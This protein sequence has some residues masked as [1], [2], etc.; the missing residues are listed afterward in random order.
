MNNIFNRIVKSIKEKINFFFYIICISLW[1]ESKV[2]YSIC[3][4]E[5]VMV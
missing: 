4:L 3:L 1:L 5:C 2:I